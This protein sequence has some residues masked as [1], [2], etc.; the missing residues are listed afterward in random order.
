MASNLLELLTQKYTHLV[1]DFS[2]SGNIQYN[3][4]YYQLV[5]LS[6]ERLEEEI[7]KCPKRNHTD[8]LPHLCVKAHFELVREI[9]SEIEIQCFHADKKL[10]TF[11]TSEPKPNLSNLYRN[12]LLR[13]GHSEEY[14]K[15]FYTS[16]PPTDFFFIKDL[17]MHCTLKQEGGMGSL[18]WATTDNSL[19][20]EEVRTL[21]EKHRDVL[22][23]F[24][25]GRV[26]YSILH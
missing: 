6:P 2:Q 4:Q 5:K 8:C 1:E 9:K 13:M 20:Q 16:N 25:L 17:S 3:F 21:A 12:A 19:S 24:K 22:D 14:A 23:L 11:T 15:Q 18:A 10:L 26:R 7:K